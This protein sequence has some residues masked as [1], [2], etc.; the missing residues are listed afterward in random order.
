MSIRQ[1]LDD[2]FVNMSKEQEQAE[3]DLLERPNVV[4][5]ALGDKITKGKATGQRA[6][7]VLVN[8]KL[9][10]DLLTADAVVEPQI[11]KY[12]TDVIDVGDIFAQAIDV[13]TPG[14]PRT[15]SKNNGS[16]AARPPAPAMDDVESTPATVVYPTPP[17]AYG[18]DTQT[19]RQRIRPVMGGFSVGH[20]AV[21]AGTVATCCYDESAFP[22]MPSRYYILSNNHVLANSNSAHLGDPILQPGVYDGGTLP[23]DVIGRLARFVPIRFHTATSK[24]LNY[25]DAAIAEVQFHEATREIFWLGYLNRRQPAVLPPL[26]IGD[27]LQKT[28]RTTNFTTGKITSLNATV[29]V[30]YGGGKVARFA[31]Q[32]ITSAMS[33]GGDSGSIVT[34]L[35]ERAVGLLFAGSSTITILNQIGLVQRLLKIRL[36]EM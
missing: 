11:G 24:P 7:Q 12:A 6:I 17:V 25:V 36:T 22:G 31:R 23:A 29:D 20:P 5:V 8:Q 18:A 35:E 21:T 14:E 33:A 3:R 16:S 30:N 15:R 34:D 2:E 27:R 9:P 13:V 26:K 28:G 10:T 19:L 32:I 4:G 1:L